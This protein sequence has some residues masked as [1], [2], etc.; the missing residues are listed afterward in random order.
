MA[1]Y[2]AAVEDAIV[3]R[4][5]E[6]HDDT[7]VYG[8]Q[9]IAVFDLDRRQRRCVDYEVLKGIKDGQAIGS[10]RFSKTKFFEFVPHVVVFAD[11]PPDERAGS[12]CDLHLL[13][14]VGEDR[15]FETDFSR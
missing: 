9:R 2:L 12:A 5:C 14:I 15:D 8:G 1:T 6:T 7:H 4:S 10:E 13:E 11:F 3:F